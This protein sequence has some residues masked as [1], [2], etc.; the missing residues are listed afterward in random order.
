V[1]RQGYENLCL[2]VN[3]LR[4]QLSTLAQVLA[5][6][7]AE[8]QQQQHHHIRMV[9]SALAPGSSVVF[10]PASTVSSAS[11]AVSTTSTATTAT[12]Q[13]AGEMTYTPTDHHRLSPIEPFRFSNSIKTISEVLSEIARFQVFKALHS[14]LGYGQDAHKQRTV[15][16][17]YCNKVPVL[18][19]VAYIQEHKGMSREEAIEELQKRFVSSH[20]TMPAFQTQLRIEQGVRDA[21]SKKKKK[22]GSSLD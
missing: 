13:Q 6:T 11:V 20:E 7:E 19:E 4:E 8:Q 21:A 1:L 14:K 5:Q 3:K 16:R 22:E 18:R 10:A 12:S 9:V 2:M 15:E 17:N